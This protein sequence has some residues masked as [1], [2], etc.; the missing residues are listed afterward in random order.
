MFVNFFSTKWYLFLKKSG[1]MFHLF[2]KKRPPLECVFEFRFLKE[3]K[4][5]RR[6]CFWIKLKFVISRKTTFLTK[7]GTFL[8][9]KSYKRLI[10]FIKE[11][12]F[13]GTFFNPKR[14]LFFRK[15]VPFESNIS[16]ESPAESHYI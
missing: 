16:Y 1:L 9:K 3:K 2:G 15:K 11:G 13:L 8:G 10:Y 5:S 7:K 6:G 14:Y 4:A 12:T